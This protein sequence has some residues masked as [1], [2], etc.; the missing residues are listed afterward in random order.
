MIWLIILGLRFGNRAMQALDGFTQTMIAH[1]EA[2]GKAFDRVTNNGK[3]PFDEAKAQ[4][5]Y[6]E[7]KKSMFDED[8]LIKDEVVRFTSGEL[9]MSLDNEL[10]NSVSNLIFKLPTVKAFC[11]IHEN[12]N[13]RSDPCKVILTS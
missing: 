6:A 5:H 2:R 4:Q 9:A 8:G 13:Q 7:I 3:L 11:V 10:T 12:S 1:A